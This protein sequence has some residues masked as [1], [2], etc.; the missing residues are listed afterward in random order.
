MWLEHQ[1]TAYCWYN[2]IYNL[3]SASIAAFVE[4]HQKITSYISHGNSPY[5]LKTI[6]IIHDLI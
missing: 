3:I 4:N 5:Y 2:S 1:V 6:L